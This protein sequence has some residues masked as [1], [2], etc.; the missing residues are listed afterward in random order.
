MEPDASP[1]PPAAPP[2][3]TIAQIQADIIAIDRRGDWRDYERLIELD[4]ELDNARRALAIARTSA[5]T[6]Q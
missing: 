5:R 1:P 2:A 4:L 3:R 6:R